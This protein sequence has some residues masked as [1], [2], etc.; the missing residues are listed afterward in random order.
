VSTQTI[1]TTKRYHSDDV[2]L[3]AITKPCHDS[4]EVSEALPIMTPCHNM[5]H[6]HVSPLILHYSFIFPLLETKAS[7]E[8]AIGSVAEP[9]SNENWQRKSLL[10]IKHVFTTSCNHQSKAEG[11]CHSSIFY[12]FFENEKMNTRHTHRNTA[13]NKTGIW[14][15]LFSI[16]LTINH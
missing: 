16:L 9:F 2:C 12:G 10:H 4:F 5:Q 15:L 11:E 7:I 1:A 13:K 8:K 14:R 6:I 3:S